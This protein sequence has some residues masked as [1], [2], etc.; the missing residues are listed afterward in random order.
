MLNIHREIKEILQ[1]FTERKDDTGD[2]ISKLIDLMDN[3]AIV[4]G[5]LETL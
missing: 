3:I 1:E 4:K 5:H 2:H